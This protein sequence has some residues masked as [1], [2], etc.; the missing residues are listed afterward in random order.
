MTASELPDNGIMFTKEGPVIVT[1]AEGSLGSK[2]SLSIFEEY[3]KD[4]I[5]VHNRLVNAGLLDLLEECHRRFGKPKQI[6][7]YEESIN[8][9]VD[10]EDIDK[11]LQAQ[12]DRLKEL[13]R[14]LSI[15]I[16]SIKSEEK[17]V[18]EMRKYLRM[19]K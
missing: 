8:G 13:E 17:N 10:T 15:I 3:R 4:P 16:E 1:F 7:A 19:S 14:N 18:E 9:S 12:E 11:K 5:A 2:R 6:L